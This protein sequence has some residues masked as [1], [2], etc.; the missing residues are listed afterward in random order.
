M[1]EEPRV[2][3]KEGIVFSIKS[4]VKTGLLSTPYTKTNSKWNK[5]LTTR[6]ET[7]KVL[8]WK[9]GG[10]LLDIILGDDFLDLV[11]KAKETKA[12]IS[13]TTSD[14]KSSAQERKP[15]TK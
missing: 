5:D 3:S 10:K 1:T 11:P 15:S 9:V 4:I 6:P 8:E 13:C 2:Y 12:K 14:W 7:L